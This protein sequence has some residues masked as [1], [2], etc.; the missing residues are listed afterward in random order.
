[1]DNIQRYK[2]IYIYKHINSGLWCLAPL[3]TICQLY[4][5]GQLNWWRKPEDPKKTS[6]MSQI[7][8]K[9]YQVHLT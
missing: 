4:R 9:L 5:G 2:F 7:T 6:D 8:E 1:M 3:S